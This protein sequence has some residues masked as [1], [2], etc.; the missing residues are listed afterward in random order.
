MIPP[1]TSGLFA[2]ITIILAIGLP[3]AVVV[4]ARA[5]RARTGAWPWV[6]HSVLVVLAQAAAVIAVLVWVNNQYGL[7]ASWDDLFGITPPAS[8]AAFNP[9]PTAATTGSASSSPAPTGVIGGNG[10]PRAVQHVPWVNGVPQGFTRDTNPNTFGTTIRVPGSGVPLPAY[11]MLPKQYF[12]AKYAKT[13]FP[14]LILLP[15]YPGTP[16]AFLHQMQLQQHLQESVAAGGT[17]FVLVITQESV[18]G[19]PDLECMDL[20]KQPQIT[21]YLTSELPNIVMSHF[22][23]RTDR[24]GWGFLGYSEGGF[25]AAQLTMRFPHLFSAAVAIAAYPRPES[26]YFAN[27]PKSYTDAG[28]LALLLAKRPPVALL[29]TE[30]TQDRQAKGVFTALKGVKPPTVVKTV[31]FTQ[32]GHN[33]QAFSLEL[34]QDFRWISNYMAKV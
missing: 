3:V 32:G 22:R 10:T 27:L 21:T 33:T 25:C 6:G 9:Q 11:V 4:T 12:E 31:L 16:E 15:G 19:S 34:A 7:Y 29:A 26:P 1:L 13:Q 18:P 5:W 24:A 14:T 23:V 20:P 30:S 28:D 17:P 2:T 8:A